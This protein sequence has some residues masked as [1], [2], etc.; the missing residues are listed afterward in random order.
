MEFD[1]EKRISA[2]KALDNQWIMQYDQS[3]YNQEVTVAALI[4]LSKYNT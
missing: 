1:P 4:N 3:K 2:E